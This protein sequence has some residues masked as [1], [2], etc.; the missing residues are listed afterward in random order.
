MQRTQ[1]Y[2]PKSQLEQ[3]KKASHQKQTTV[4]AL[5]RAAL[6][7]SKALQKTSPEKPYPTFTETLAKI[8]KLKIK[9]ERDLSAKVDYYLY[10]RED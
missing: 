4:S 3:L 7:E 1:I 5:I 9:G 8:K 6:K 10:G 2:L